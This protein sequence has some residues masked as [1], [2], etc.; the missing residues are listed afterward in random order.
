MNIKLDI[1]LREII[2]HGDYCIYVI[3]YTSAVSGG[4]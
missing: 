2:F 1:I 4:N 3:I